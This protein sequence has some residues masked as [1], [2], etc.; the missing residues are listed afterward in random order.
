MH[1]DHLKAYTRS[2][3]RGVEE[4]IWNAL[5][6]DADHVRVEIQRN[7]LGGVEAV[8]VEDDGH[9][10]RPDEVDDL[11]GRLGGSWKLFATKT[12]T[13]GRSLHG[14]H[15]RGRWYAFGL[16]GAIVVWRTI[17]ELPDGERVAT[18]VQGEAHSLTRFSITGPEPTDKP[19]GTRVSIEG[20]AEDPT[21]LL[22]PRAVDSL[23]ARFALHIERFG[24]TITF[25]GARLD[26]AS[27]QTRRDELHL[28]VAT[29]FGP[30]DVTVVEWTRHF[31]P[32]VFL[33]DPDGTVLGVT[34]ISGV[35]HK[36]S[37][38]AYARWQGF[39]QFEDL[40]ELQEMSADIAP[41]IDSVRS[42]LQRHFTDRDRRARQDLIQQWKDEAAYPYD[43]EP[44][45]PIGQTEREIFDVV[46][47]AAA[48]AV[49][50]A[51]DVRARRFSLAMLREALLTGP[52]SL[53]RVLQEVLDL[54]PDKVAELDELLS[55]TSLASIIAAS[56]RIADRLDFLELLRQ[57]VFDPE[58]K[59]LVKERSQLHRILERETWVFGEEFALTA[60]DRTL[61]TVL[62]A[63]IALL[64]R[65]EL[66][67]ESVSSDSKLRVDL[68]LARSMEQQ[69][70]RQEHLV[71]ELKRPTTRIDYEEINQTTRYATE[72]ARDPQFNKVDVKWDFVIVGDEFGDYA[73]AMTSQVGQPQ[74]LVASPGGLR[75]WARTW[76]QVISAADHRLKFVR[77]ALE[78]EPSR[79]SAAAYLHRVHELTLAMKAASSESAGSE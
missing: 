25:D 79:T 34:A 44:V 10:M 45:D 78:Y 39:R 60:S 41:V 28:D 2:P 16:R 54:P 65:Q 35:P 18:T 67:P 33:C 8:H 36:Y 53:T 58:T 74:G 23:T 49:N 72:V 71:V 14:R 6:A 77:A 42:A 12:R 48:T 47:V 68:M 76:A 26:P 59:K 46:A 32:E 70:D 4:L 3:L 61:N 19:P 24:E 1:E 22:S 57:M 64:G 69:R 63:H 66:A 50:A 9:G 55:G 21:P 56:R 38:T 31:E 37:F 13:K 11:F 15:G 40:L 7:K 17:A 75:V 43:E 62:K 20:I 52:S 27:L 30:V 29:P 73:E 5:D 51:S